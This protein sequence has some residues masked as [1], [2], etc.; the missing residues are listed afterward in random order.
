ML[1]Q[2]LF[3]DISIAGDRLQ[4]DYGDKTGVSTRMGKKSFQPY[5]RKDKTLD[6]YSVYSVYSSS[7][8]NLTDVLLALKKKSY[9]KMDPAD[10]QHFL[11]R[12]AIYITAKILRPLKIDVVVTPRSS[13]NILN[14]LLAELQARNPH[15]EFLPESY[16]KTADISKIQVDRSH[17]AITDAIAK[18]LEAII[19]AAQKSG[20]FEIKKALPQNRKFFKNFFEVVDP[21]LTRKFINRN[22]CVFDDVLSSGTTVVQIMK[23]IA[24]YGPAT[25]AG[26]VIFKTK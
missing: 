24:V 16:V 22:V 12:T 5:L 9:V 7:D 20:K 14:D 15:I 8:E 21:A 17:P 13:T 4:F 18:S 3:D 6:G 2:H 19:R 23:D 11:R 25:V 1:L 10:Y 26:C